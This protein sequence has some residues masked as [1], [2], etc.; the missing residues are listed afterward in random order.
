MYKAKLFLFFG[1]WVAILPYLGLPIMLK[2]I[3]FSVTGLFLIYIGLVI[4]SKTP[5]N[6]SGNQFD[7]FSENNWNSN[8]KNKVTDKVVQEV[9]IETRELVEEQQ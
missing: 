9:F 3:L 1:I 6:L 8:K 5:K 2:N 4:R 7:N